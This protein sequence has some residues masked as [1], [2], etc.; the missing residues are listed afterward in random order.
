MNE[1][2][3]ELP[4]QLKTSQTNILPPP[5]LPQL[6]SNLTSSHFQQ[7]VS[8]LKIPFPGPARVSKKRESAVSKVGEY[9]ARDKCLKNVPKKIRNSQKV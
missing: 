8:K 7:I 6:I 5:S 3:I 2:S 4:G 1:V 9:K